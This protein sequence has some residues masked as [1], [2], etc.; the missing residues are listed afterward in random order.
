MIE[1]EDNEI[2]DF[3]VKN[4]TPENL[5]ASANLLYNPLLQLVPNFQL[6]KSKDQSLLFRIE[7]CK[8]D[9]MSELDKI[10]CFDIMERNMKVVYHNVPIR[11]RLSTIIENVQTLQLGLELEK[12]EERAVPLS[13]S[14]HRRSGDRWITTHQS[15]RPF[16]LRDRLQ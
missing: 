10:S 9:D 11:P 1:T 3:S 14:F 5:V 13:V 16:P 6:F 8:A 2:E 15:V 7:C 12:E 4:V